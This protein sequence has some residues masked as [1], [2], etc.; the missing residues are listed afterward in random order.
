MA[1]VGLM[2]VEPWIKRYIDAL[3]SR[4][5]YLFGEIGVTTTVATMMVTAPVIWWHFGRFSPMALLSNTLVL[6]M[7]PILMILGVVMIVVGGWIS[8]P[9]YVI[10]HMMV[11][12]IRILGK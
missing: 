8:L 2:V 12:I 11:L 5:L 3:N 4:L 7:V 1:S 9:V 10:S 6:P